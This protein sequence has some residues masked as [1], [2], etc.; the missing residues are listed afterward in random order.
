MHLAHKYWM[1]VYILDVAEAEDS[2]RREHF[3]W[4]RRIK[5]NRNSSWHEFKEGPM[6][7]LP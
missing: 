5:H 4:E 6:K 3:R 2:D 7:I 1:C